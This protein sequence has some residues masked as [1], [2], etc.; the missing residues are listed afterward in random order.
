MLTDRSSGYYSSWN[1]INAPVSVPPGKKCYFKFIAPSSNSYAFGSDFLRNPSLIY[2]IGLVNKSNTTQPSTSSSFDSENIFTNL[3]SSDTT[4][5][6]K[7]YQKSNASTLIVADGTNCTSNCPVYF[8]ITKNTKTG[9]CSSTR[10][11]QIMAT[12]PF[13]LRFDDTQVSIPST[14]SFFDCYYLFISPKD[15]V[16][17][18]TQTKTYLAGSAVSMVLSVSAPVTA[19]TTTFASAATNTDTTTATVNGLSTSA[20]QGRYVKATFSNTNDSQNSF[21]LSNSY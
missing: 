7:F 3:P 20:G 6:Y 19:V 2:H 10:G 17:Q 4:N 16:S 11:S 8:T 9:D 14:G 15:T 5:Q 1:G 18:F 13:V 21:N 12:S